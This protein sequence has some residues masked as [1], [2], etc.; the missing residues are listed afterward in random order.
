MDNLKRMH[1]VPSFINEEIGFNYLYTK[2]IKTSY[3]LHSVSFFNLPALDKS[4]LVLKCLLYIRYL[5]IFNTYFV[6]GFRILL[7]P[8]LG[9]YMYV[10]L[11]TTRQRKIYGTS[12]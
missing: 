6:W 1:S 10:Y 9:H 8:N 4:S 2:G 3:Y 12:K 7:V 5:L 11:L